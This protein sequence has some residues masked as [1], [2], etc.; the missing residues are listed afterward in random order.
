M[1]PEQRRRNKRVALILVAL[2]AAL[3]VWTFLRGTVLF[4]R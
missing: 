4:A 2:V 1:T 3:F